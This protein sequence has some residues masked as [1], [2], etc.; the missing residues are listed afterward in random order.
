MSVIQTV[1]EDLTEEECY[2]WAILS[3]HSGIDQAE[4]CWVDESSTDGCWRAWSFQVPWWR[5]D[6][7]QQIEQSGRSLGK[8]MS[9]MARACAFPFVHPGQEMV[10]TA[11]ELVHLEP[12]VSKI[13]AQMYAVRL[14]RDL[15][16]TGRSGVTHRPFQM[17]FLNQARIIGRIP[18]KDGRGV[19]GCLGYG[20]LVWTDQGLVPVEQVQKGDMVLTHQGRFRPVLA[21]I[22]DVNDCYEVRGQQSF[23]MTVSCD[24]R[25]LGIDNDDGQFSDPMFVDVEVLDDIDFH[26]A[27]PTTFPS[28]PVPGPAFDGD[29]WWATG[30]YLSD[31]SSTP[32][33]AWHQWIKEHFGESNDRRF[34]TFVLGMNEEWRFALLFGYLDRCWNDEYE[35]WE[36]ESASKSFAVGVQ[37]LAQSLGL[38]VDCEESEDSWLI[39]LTRRGAHVHS[40]DHVYGKVKSVRAVGKKSIVNL[41]VD[42]DHSYVSG[43]IISHNLHPVWLEMDES[44]DYPHDGWVELAETV[45]RT[46][47]GATWRAHGVTR[48][49]RDDFYKY[50]RDSPDNPWTVHRYPA[51]YRP[52]WSDQEREDK[53]AQYGGRDDPDYR[54]NILGLP[55]DATQALFVLSRLMKCHP[56]STPVHRVIDNSVTRVPI[57]SIKVGDQVLTATGIG[58][59]VA[60][61]RS[62]RSELIRVTIA[63]E[64][65]ACT[66]EH[67]FL[68]PHGWRHADQLV[69][70]DQIIDREGLWKLWENFEVGTA[71]VL[72][73]GMLSGYSN[74]EIAKEA[75]KVEEVRSLLGRVSVQDRGEQTRAEVLL[76]SLLEEDLDN[77]AGEVSSVP[78]WVQEKNQNAEVLFSEMCGISKTQQQSQAI[79][80]LP[81]L[82]GRDLDGQRDEEVLFSR[83]LAHLSTARQDCGTCM[84][85]LWSKVPGGRG[86]EVLFQGMCGDGTGGGEAEIGRGNTNGAHL[87]EMR[88]GVS[89]GKSQSDVLFGAMFQFLQSGQAETSA[90]VVSPM[91]NSVQS[92]QIRDEVLLSPM[93][94]GV[95]EDRTSCQKSRHVLSEQGNRRYDETR[96]QAVACAKERTTG[97]VAKVLDESVWG[98]RWSSEH[99]RGFCESF[100]KDC[101]RGRWSKSLEQEADRKGHCSGQMAGLPRVDAVEVLEPGSDGFNRFSNGEDQ[102]DVCD[103]TIS[104]HPSFLVGEA[105]Y[106][107]HNCSD[108]DVTSDYNVD[109][110][111]NLK[112][113][114]ETLALMDQDILDV[115]QLPP[116]HLKYLGPDPSKPKAV[117]W[118]GMDIGMTRDPSEILVFVEYRENPKDEFPRLKLLTRI[119][120]TRIDV[121][122]Q[123]KV[124]LSV[125]DFYKPRVFAMDRGGL[126]LPFLQLIKGYAENPGL[127]PEWAKAFRLQDSLSRIKGYNFGEKIVV[128][129]DPTVEVDE[130]NNPEKEAGMRRNT[131]EYGIDKLRELVDNRQLQLPWDEELL[132]QFQGGTVTSVAGLDQYGRRRFSKG[133]DHT[134]DA[135]VMMTLGFKQYSIEEFLAREEVV[136]P[137]Y[138]VFISL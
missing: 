126:G 107:V 99:S 1:Y 65:I 28:L 106:V 119:S 34:P 53:I 57:E 81:N 51:M 85:A 68:T 112:I 137:V 120:M 121:S 98:D 89:Q 90:K 94:G 56:P 95:K 24:H 67:P 77:R 8:S 135:A 73:K 6:D 36:A 131:K 136:E 25:F 88:E 134:L 75:A 101:F 86:A 69:P 59:V 91:W 38:S 82:R 54:R 70:G 23:P 13:E 87:H 17:N 116:R 4:M 133:D 97:V 74:E 3:D 10:V 33:V 138:D 16:V 93:L 61:P 22:H 105:G 128:E 110:Y 7:R 42:D 124:I 46:I 30:R 63:G 35:R 62:K 127:Q 108:D 125:I 14:Y 117:Y 26:W 44:Q 50:T 103:L 123:T 43:A 47:E 31:D 40:D 114:S 80:V 27:S 118:V 96:V 18:Q 78:G 76:K 55:G 130:G 12:I 132:G 84:R 5:N 79:D 41:V 49:V 15:L 48:G 19:K 71:E 39:Q 113:K 9:I 109:E 104:G 29:F 115:V 72:F 83:L 32:T 37:M 102:V 52:T 92:N 58:E 129:L 64:S 66:P 11:P 2:L 21:V 60:T 111:L 45:N 100:F 20:E 122:G